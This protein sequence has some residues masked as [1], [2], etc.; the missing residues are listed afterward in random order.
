MGGRQSDRTRAGFGCGMLRRP[1]RR[2]PRGLSR[3]VLRLPLSLAVGPIINACPLSSSG[4]PPMI[5]GCARSTVISANPPCCE[6]RADIFG[7]REGGSTF[8]SW[9]RRAPQLAERDAAADQPAS[10]PLGEWRPAGEHEAPAR[11]RAPPMLRKAAIGSANH[12]TPMREVAT[13]NAACS[14]A[15]TCASPGS[16]VIL[17]IPPL[18]QPAAEQR[19]AS[20]RRCRPQRRGHPRRPLLPMG[21]HGTGAA[22]D[23][24][25]A[26]ARREAGG[27]PAAARRPPVAPLPETGPGDPT[28]PGDGVPPRRPPSFASG[29]PRLSCTISV[30][31]PL[32]MSFGIRRS[33]RV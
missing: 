12:T 17:C 23:F 18:G 9:L 6:K 21:P 15:I 4:L 14:N 8:F 16:S 31:G 11:S 7:I 24:E 26:L 5:V 20:A 13:S 2:S 25:H 3:R 27:K 22:A 28:R 33:F 19:R 32:I 29:V 30:F 1:P 10:R